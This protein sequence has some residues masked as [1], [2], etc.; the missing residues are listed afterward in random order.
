LFCSVLNNNNGQLRKDIFLPFFCKWNC[1]ENKNVYDPMFGLLCNVLLISLE[2]DEEEEEKPSESKRWFFI[3][4]IFIKNL[5]EKED[6]EGGWVR[7]WK[8]G[9]WEEWGGMPGESDT[10]RQIHMPRRQPGSRH[11]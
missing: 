3:R 5:H 4:N 10:Y 8:A 11:T 2:E 1:I 7:S 6:R 9:S